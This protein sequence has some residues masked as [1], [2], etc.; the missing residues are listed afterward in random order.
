MLKFIRQVC[1]ILAALLQ[2]SGTAQADETPPECMFKD[3]KL[4][5]DF[6]VF[7]VGGYSGRPLSFAIDKSGHTAGW[8]NVTVNAPGKPVALLLGNYEPTIWNILWTP[9]TKVTAVYAAG[10]GRQMV[11]GV[12]KDTAVLT[13]SISER[14]GFASPCFFSNLSTPEAIGRL[15]MVS[16]TVFNRKPEKF[17]RSGGDNPVRMGKMKPVSADGT[18]TFAREVSRETAAPPL[19]TPKGDPF[20]VTIGPT[21]PPGTKLETFSKNAAARPAQPTPP[22]PPPPAPTATIRPYEQPI[23]FGAEGYAAAV[24]AGALR[25]A[26]MADVD[27]FIKVYVKFRPPNPDIPP[28]QGMDK[29]PDLRL[30]TITNIDNSYVILKNWFRIPHTDPRLPGPNVFLA[31]GVENPI[32]DNGSNA[33]LFD[34]NTG[35]CMTLPPVSCAPRHRVAKLDDADHRNSYFAPHSPPSCW[36][37]PATLPKDFDVIA[38]SVYKGRPLDFTIDESGHNA[39]QVDVKVNHPEKPVALLLGAYEPTV[40]NIMR[41][42]GTRIAAVLIG[43]YDDQQTASLD[44]SVPVIGRTYYS[45]KAGVD[46]ICDYFQLSGEEPDLEKINPISRQAFGKNVSIYVPVDANSIMRVGDRVSA[47][48]YVSDAG[49]K[50][51]SFHDTNAPLTGEAGMKEAL[52]KGLIRPATN[53]DA[54]AWVAAWVAK[55]PENPDFPTT[56]L[57]RK[58]AVYPVFMFMQF[59]YVIEK[60]FKIPPGAR[61][62]FIIPKGVPLP[63]GDGAASNY[64]YDVNSAG[65]LPRPDC[66][67]FLMD[68]NGINN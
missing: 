9:G 17:L 63:E 52:A 37:D 19:P 36:F 13:N 64:F 23:T 68:S 66:L 38:G 43:G 18:M 8:V 49:K 59:T 44:P 57:R 42:P 62:F 65:C 3:A 16:L 34:M 27:D 53:K 1:F 55:N 29:V 41:T 5:A 31:P 45:N 12:G 26:T 7:A 50:P 51:E 15:D 56:F 25:K 21:V 24:A 39:G 67:M 22:P 6:R 40:W 35:D 48:S 54:R 60:P 11:Y 2:L 61:G 46:G 10:Y 58:G 30:P 32:L 4:P 14:P 20:S 47:I 28:V 33:Y